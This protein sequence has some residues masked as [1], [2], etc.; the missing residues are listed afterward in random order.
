MFERIKNGAAVV[1]ALAL[2]A[3]PFA[4]L[5]FVVWVVIHFVRK[6]W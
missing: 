2:I 6:Y 5:I 4:W 1:L 3:L